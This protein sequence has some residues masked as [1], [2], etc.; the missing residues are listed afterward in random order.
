M[1]KS[2]DPKI[3]IPDPI[4]LPAIEIP[5][6]KIGPTT[7][8]KDVKDPIAPEA[9]ETPPPIT[10]PPSENADPAIPPIPDKTFEPVPNILLISG[11]EDDIFGEFDIFNV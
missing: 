1:A 3:E 5:V 4:T 9:K 10:L 7:G 11:C 8:I 6:P 2:K